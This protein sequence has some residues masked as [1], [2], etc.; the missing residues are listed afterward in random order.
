M[1]TSST[2]SS[3]LFYDEDEDMEIENSK[4]IYDEFNI[5][6]SSPDG[7]FLRYN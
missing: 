1:D 4:Q 2:E 6:E 7:N 5:A 3:R